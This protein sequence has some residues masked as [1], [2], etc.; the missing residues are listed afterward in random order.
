MQRVSEPRRSEL[1][2]VLLFAGSITIT[3]AVVW[4]A[5]SVM[6]AACFCMYHWLGHT[7]TVAVIFPCLYMLESLTF[8]LLDLPLSLSQVSGAQRCNVLLFA[9]VCERPSSYVS[10]QI[11]ACNTSFR[12]I[13]VRRR[14]LC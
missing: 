10:R 6:G 5:S 12:R 9:V 2:G 13:V 8:P 3:M 4:S 14:A 11:A 7:L 1:R